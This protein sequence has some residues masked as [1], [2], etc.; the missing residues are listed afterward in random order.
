MNPVVDGTAAVV[1]TVSTFDP[2]NKRDGK[3]QNCSFHV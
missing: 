2:S 3:M 1:V